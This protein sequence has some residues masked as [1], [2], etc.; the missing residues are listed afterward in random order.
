MTTIA[1][2]AIAQTPHLSPASMAAAQRDLVAKTIREFTHERLIRPVPVGERW[3]LRAGGTTYT[4][5]A[6]QHPLEHLAID[7]ASLRRADAA[8]VEL[9]LDAQ[10]LVLDLSG[11]LGIPDNLMDTY[12]E[13][14]A[15]TLQAA[16]WVHHRGGPDAATLA[17]ADWQTVERSMTGH[18]C[19]VATNGRIGFGLDDYEAYAPEAGMPFAPFW[20]AVRR[21]AAQ[22]SLGAGLDEESFYQLELGTDLHRFRAALV[23]RRLDPDAYHLL[24]THP[25]QWQHKLAI[26]YAPAV[27]RAEIVPLGPGSDQYQA[28]QSI[29]T[30]ANLDR[31]E[32]AYV[33]VALSVQNMGFLRGL[34]SRYMS[35]TPAI[36]DFVHDLVEGDEDLQERG[37]SVLRERAAIGWSGGVHTR[38]DPASAYAKMSAA[39][40]RESPVPGLADGERLVTM[41]SL[42]HRDRA[43]ESVAAELISASGLESVEW[44]RHYLDAYL[45]PVLHCL[46]AHDLAFMPHGENLMLVLR[47]HRVVRVIMKDIGEEVA[48]LSER[49][50]P[51]G[52]DRIRHVVDARERE[53]CIFTDVFDGVLRHLGAT[54]AAVG[55]MEDAAFWAVVARVIVEHRAEYPELH[56]EYD[57]FRPEFRHTCLNRLQLRNTTQMVDLTDQ[58]NSL[59]HVGEIGNPIAPYAR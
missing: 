45:R 37:F 22:L 17:H 4:F 56:A 20:V 12:L 36:N 31:P 51:A 26:T 35:A 55:V 10:E 43:G 42:L 54:L 39:L 59:I 21:D 57:F 40:W 2:E 33:K 3:S 13:E 24:P 19:F 15:S 34:S 11:V 58:V 9:P 18:P 41:A 14:V 23:D 53:M 32:R 27:G 5:A 46:L 25:W 29:R 8:G 1:P 52:I 28:Q 47:D 6:T 16:A 7:P 49:A 30:L 50:L 44:L 48:V 38:R